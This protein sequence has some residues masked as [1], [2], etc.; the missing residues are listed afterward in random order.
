MTGSTTSEGYP[1]PLV[2]DFA[3]VQDAFR[4]AQAID[5]DLRTAQAP[6]RAFMGRPSFIG[7]QVGNQTGITSGTQ[8]LTMNTVE[9][10][11]TGGLI[12]GNNF[13]SQ[14]LSQPPSWWLFGATILV[15]PTSTL[16]VG[17]LNIGQIVYQTADQ[18]TGVLTLSSAYQRNDDTNTNG[19]WINLFTMGAI[20]HGAAQARLTVDGSTAKGIQ[21]S[22]RFWGLYMGP[23][24]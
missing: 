13:W 17:D 11:N 5:T 9:W 19:E 21:A 23:V 6:L 2:S 1:Y 3:D 8:Y 20:Y 16:V 4:L 22:S 24:N 12:A 14:P 18:I 15:K 10:D 7:Q